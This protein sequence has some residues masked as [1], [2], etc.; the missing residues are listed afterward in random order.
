M[1]GVDTSS[2]AMGTWN[3]QD[4]EYV[5]V[6]QAITHNNP[7]AMGSQNCSQQQYTLDFADKGRRASRHNI[8]VIHVLVLLAIIQNHTGNGKPEL[9]A[10]SIRSRCQRIKVGVE[11]RLV[12]TISQKCRPNN[13]DVGPNKHKHS[14][15][16][17]TFPNEIGRVFK[18]VL[19]QF[20]III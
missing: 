2:T 19:F 10:T 15:I 18:I 8:S 17:R 4:L 11:V 13:L 1:L 7:Q 16:C 6:T 9:Q 12:R 14:E 5:L 20:F 3:A